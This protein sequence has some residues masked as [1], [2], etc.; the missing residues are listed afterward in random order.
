[1]YSSA[2]A[3]RHTANHL[4]KLVVVDFLF[5]FACFFGVFNSILQTYCNYKVKW[6]PEP[7]S[8]RRIGVL[9]T[10]ALPLGYQAMYCGKQQ[11][12]I[13]SA[14]NVDILAL[15]WY[16]LD[17][18]DRVSTI[19]TP[20]NQKYYSGSAVSSAGQ[21]KKN[22]FAFVLT[23]V[24]V[25]L[26]CYFGYLLVN[27]FFF[28]SAK[29]YLDADVYYGK[30]KV[31]VNGVEAGETPLENYVVKKGSG[32]V[33]FE[34]DAGVAYETTVPFEA[35][36]PSLVKRDLGVDEVFSSGFSLWYEKSDTGNVL[37]VISEPSDA[38]VFIDG[39]EVGKTPFAS[40]KL[41]DG[42]YE[43]RIEKA[44]YEPQN[45][46]LSVFKDQKVNVAFKLFPLPAP[47]SVKLMTGST[48]I[49]DVNSADSIITAN[50]QQWAKALVYW[51][52]TRGI[53][54][55]GYGINR[56]FVFKYVLDFAGNFYDTDASAVDPEKVV[57]ADGKIAYLRKEADVEGVSAQA[58]ESLAKIG[59]GAGL[60]K[61]VKVIT[62]PTGW[63]RVRSTASLN[64][65][66]VGRLSVG[67]IV[68]VIEESAGWVKIKS[69]SGLEG[70]ASA[71]YL[72]SL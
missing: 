38:L 25:V 18:A 23:A 10:P 46:R 16:F 51:N 20:V 42:A 36:Y 15:K 27:R 58:K 39:S 9:Q 71:D 64:G 31:S 43:L 5:Q 65:T 24:G 40:D 55:M 8:N 26:T 11:L 17:M 70:W 47:A 72:Q 1:M 61:S 35:G 57:L 44:N 29:P 56:D 19:F 66:E 12:I 68:T 63:L 33:R 59:T 28:P 34:G 60:G 37:S 3:Q 41:T 53:N 32:T 67:D 62:T 49:Y 4:R 7:E 45:F 2:D 48:N 6:R 14:V 54:I 69:A 21:K 22:I 30:A 52:K 13:N 50:P